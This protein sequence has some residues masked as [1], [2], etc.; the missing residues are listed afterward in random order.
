MVRVGLPA[1][2]EDFPLATSHY[3]GPQLGASGNLPSHV[4]LPIAAGRML[5]FSCILPMK[6]HAFG[7]KYR[8][9]KGAIISPI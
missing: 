4:S 7:Y 6:D 2:R 5:H 8:G 9:L 1:S 3:L